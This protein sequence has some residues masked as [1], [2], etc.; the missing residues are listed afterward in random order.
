MFIQS[1]FP[2]SVNLIKDEIVDE[3]VFLEEIKKEKNEQK[4]N[5]ETIE[6]KNLTYKYPKTENRVLENINFKFQRKN[7]YSNWNKWVM[8]QH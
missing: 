3:Q 1:I 6:I 4:I 5:V 2:N 8:K 7:K